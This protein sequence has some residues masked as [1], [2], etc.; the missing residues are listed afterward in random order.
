MPLEAP[1]LLSLRALVMLLGVL[2]CAPL[3]PSSRRRCGLLTALLVPLLLPLMLPAFPARGVEA[4]RLVLLRAL[5][6]L[7]GVPLGMLQM[8][9][10]SS[11]SSQPLL[12]FPARGVEA[13]RILLLRALVM[14]LGVL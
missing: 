11:L 9:S 3:L 8:E 14:L 4:S 13:P 5:V 12:A 10:P 7:L 6:M 1:R 2:P